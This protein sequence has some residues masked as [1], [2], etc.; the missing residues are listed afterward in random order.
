ML[1]SRHGL[2][3]SAKKIEEKA[4][5]VAGLDISRGMSNMTHAETTRAFLAKLPIDTQKMVLENIAR[6]YGINTAEAFAEITDPEAE[7]L[8]DYVTGPQRAATQVLMQRHGF[9]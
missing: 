8:L 4:C 7:H 6:H 2:K 1:L 3:G 5:G 9:N